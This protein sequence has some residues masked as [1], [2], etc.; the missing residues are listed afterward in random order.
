MVTRKSNS[1]GRKKE[2]EDMEDI[3]DGPLK[4]RRYGLR[5]D[6]DVEVQVIAGNTLITVE[7]R[8]LSMK[9]DLEIIDS[10]GN[11]HKIFMDWIVDI[12]IIGHNRPRPEN[13]P[14]ITKKRV[15]QKPKKRVV[16]HAYN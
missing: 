16:D 8:V 2:E 9:N 12:K 7:G 13:D 6:D 1:R 5:I 10:D 4:K 14:E 3:F 15:K 11:Y